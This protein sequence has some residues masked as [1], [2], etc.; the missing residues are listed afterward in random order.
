VE[1]DAGV[2]LAYLLRANRFQLARQQV[3][4]ATRHRGD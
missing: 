1:Q 2:E 4:Q 3:G